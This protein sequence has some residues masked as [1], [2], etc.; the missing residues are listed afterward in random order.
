MS[1]PLLSLENTTLRLGGRTLW[2]DLDLAVQPGE[3]IAILG[4]NG[5][6]KTS[7]LRG[8]LGL[9]E[10]AKGDVAVQGKPPRRGNSDIG[11]IPQ[12][13]TFDRDLPI[14]GRDLVKLGLIGHRFGF[15]R[16]SK[17]GLQRVNEV[18]HEV[19][20]SRYADK[21]LGLL[22]GGEQQRLRIAQSLLGKPRLLFCDEPLSS[23]DLQ[24]QRSIS[25]LID[26]YRKQNNAAVLFVTHDINP[27]L[28]MVDRVLYLVNGK[29]AIGTPEEVLT[30]EL[31]SRLYETPVDVLKVRGRIVVVNASDAP[32]QS[33]HHH[34]PSSHGSGGTV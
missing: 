20:A 23:L 27:V 32:E 26:A 7:L 19:G 11:Y 13:K 15:V 3:F 29:W 12:Q 24:S 17:Q 9:H 8:L 14:R 28:D 21:P 34:V 18:I 6:G 22:S 4:P 10:F 25:E 2:K 33:G 5:A 16:S 31:L 30:T 1:E